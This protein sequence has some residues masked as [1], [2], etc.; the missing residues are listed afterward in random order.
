MLTEPDGQISWPT[1]KGFYFFDTRLISSWRIYANGEEWDLLNSGSVTHF[2]S[3]V[4]LINRKVPTEAGD[5]PPRTVSL[6][7]SRS[8][9]EGI[10]EDLDLVNNGPKPVR[11][12]LEIAIRGDFADIFEVKS[13]HIVRRGRITSDWSFDPVRLRIPK[14]GFLP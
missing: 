11:F 13:G 9:G 6:V 2:A 5:I 1:Q 7:L 8:I 3:R 14:Q 12:N 10:H 4:F